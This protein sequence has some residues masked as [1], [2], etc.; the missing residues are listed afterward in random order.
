MDRLLITALACLI[1]L[2]LFAQNIPEHPNKFDDDGFKTG[3]W[4]ILY[5]SEWNEIQNLDSVEFYRVINYNKGVPNGKVIDYYLNGNKQWE[6]YLLFDNPIEIL[7]GECLW[8]N[9][10]SLLNQVG[11]Y[12]DS[13]LNGEFKN[14][15]IHGN[16]IQKKYFKDGLINGSNVFYNAEGEEC[17]KLIYSENNL[18]DFDFWDTNLDSSSYIVLD[19]ICNRYTRIANEN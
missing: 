1:S 11:N 9:K 15:N 8:Y 10:N 16:L 3:N 13:V 5:D 14:Y 17:L 7:D 6:G 4:T 19:T 12:R 18:T 2:N